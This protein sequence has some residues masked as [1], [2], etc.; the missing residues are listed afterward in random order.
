MNQTDQLI[1]TSLNLLKKLTTNGPEAAFTIPV[2]L[3]Q[4]PL[5]Q[6]FINQLNE[7]VLTYQEETSYLH[8]LAAGNLSITPP[9]QHRHSLAA[10]QIQA[11][12]THLLWQL[13]QLAAGD[14]AQQVD[15]SGLFAGPIKKLSDNLRENQ[16]LHAQVQRSEEFYKTLVR[17]SPDGITVIDL[18]GN[19]IL[20]SEKGARMFGYAI[21]ELI[22]KSYMNVLTPLSQSIAM[23]RIGLMLKGVYTG[24]HRYEVIKKS[25]EHFWIEANAEVIRST[26]GDPEAIM[27]VYRDVS[28]KVVLEKKMEEHSLLLEQQAR[29]D[30]MTG[31][32]NRMAGLE[33]LTAEMVRAG[34]NSLNLTVGFVDID[35][36]KKINDTYGHS[37]GDRI[38]LALVDCIKK[39]IRTT[40][41]IVRMGGDEFLLLFPECEPESVQTIVDRIEH[42]VKET[43][44][45]RKP[46]EVELSFS[47]GLAHLNPQNPIQPEDLIEQ[48]DQTMYRHKKGRK[49]QARPDTS[50]IDDLP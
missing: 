22:G 15:F 13:E 45:Q 32:L 48:A 36:L 37:E 43:N 17:I 23:E 7:F 3:A 41:Q 20:V 42:C 28:W 19:Q 2:D 30:R 16:Q 6:E 25:G 35:D 33:L 27:L 38:I 5:E 34:E 50:P 47:Y 21:D 9:R 10:R 26:S 31:T 24:I 44:L 29:S 18:Q 39:C 4:T 8:Q 40:D 14:L 49:S 46:D 1:T 12:L 11:E